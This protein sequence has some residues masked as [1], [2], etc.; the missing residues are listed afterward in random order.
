[1]AALVLVFLLS[2]LLVAI[3]KGAAAAGWATL[4]LL[5]GSIPGCSMTMWFGLMAVNLG[6][7]DPAIPGASPILAAV[8]FWS[9]IWIGGAALGAVCA[10][11]VGQRLRRPEPHERRCATCGYLLIGLPERRCPECGQPF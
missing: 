1:M 11:W 8:R 9:A 2:L 4:G 6:A 3:W 7:D 5:V 10:F